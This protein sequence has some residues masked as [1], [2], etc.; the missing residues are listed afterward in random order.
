MVLTSRL[1]TMVELV[2]EK[3]ILRSTQ[4]KEISDE[5]GPDVTRGS[6]S[7]SSSSMIYVSGLIYLYSLLQ[8]KRRGETKH[9]PSR[10]QGY[11]NS[12]SPS[13]FFSF[14]LSFDSPNTHFKG[15]G[16]CVGWIQ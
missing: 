2:G 11:P 7:A 5:G 13:K 12:S 4:K 8:L 10:H 1:T 6:G 14:C 15:S 9:Q 16:H 3:P